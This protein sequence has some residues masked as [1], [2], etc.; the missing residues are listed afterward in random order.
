MIIT[1]TKT[2]L[3]DWEI[4]DLTLF[5][6]YQEPKYKW[7]QFDGPYFPSR[8]AEQVTK[9]VEKRKKMVIDKLGPVGKY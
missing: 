1:G 8:T 9:A 6:E 4:K 2:N 3:R 7:H 5:K